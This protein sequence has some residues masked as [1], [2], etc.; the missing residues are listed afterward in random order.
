[1]PLLLL[2]MLQGGMVG[3]N[4]NMMINC[5]CWFFTQ[6][7]ETSLSLLAKKLEF[8]MTEMIFSGSQVGP[9]SV[10]PDEL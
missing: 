6:V 7:Q 3:N 10:Q 1:M 2:E 9:D 4:I 5:T 8:F